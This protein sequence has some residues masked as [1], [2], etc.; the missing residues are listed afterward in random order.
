M[1]MHVYGLSPLLLWIVASLS[2]TSVATST[3]WRATP[4]QN[5]IAYEAVTSELSSIG[6]VRSCSRYSHCISC[7]FDEMAGICYLHPTTASEPAE[8]VGNITAYDM[9]NT[10]TCLEMELPLNNTEVTWQRTLTSLV[11]DFTCVADYV[12]SENDT[13]RVTCSAA[14]QWLV[15]GLGICRRR[16]WRNFTLGD[17]NYY[18]VPKIPDVGWKVCIT[19][20]PTANH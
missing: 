12:Y 7:A 5:V 20:V 17:F 14:G 18:D 10:P 8:P 16:L 2:S 19:G 3:R 1:D 6:C 9:D 15:E 11:G 4:K 13:T